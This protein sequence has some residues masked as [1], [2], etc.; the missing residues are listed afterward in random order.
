M[1]YFPLFIFKLIKKN[2]HNFEKKKKQNSILTWGF[3]IN[4]QNIEVFVY[5]TEQRQQMQKKKIILKVH[6]VDDN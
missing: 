2:I 6:I 3:E 1:P 4:F 5:D